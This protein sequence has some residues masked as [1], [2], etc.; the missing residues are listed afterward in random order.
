MKHCIIVVDTDTN[1]NSSQNNDSFVAVP[2]ASRF[3]LPRMALLSG[4]TQ[5]KAMIAR[6]PSVLTRSVS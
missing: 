1:T 6:G 5:N 3:D 4:H 2:R